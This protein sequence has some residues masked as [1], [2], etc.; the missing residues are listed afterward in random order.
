MTMTTDAG[1]VLYCDDC[2]AIR[3]YALCAAHQHLWGKPIANDVRP[4]GD[5]P[6]TSPVTLY[7]SRGKDSNW[8]LAEEIWPRTECEDQKRAFSYA[9]LEVALGCEVDLTTGRVRVLSVAGV[10]LERPT[11]WGA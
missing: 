9:L 1:A 8:E 4:Q 5:R 10:P 6:K 11:D 7:A 2:Y 3:G